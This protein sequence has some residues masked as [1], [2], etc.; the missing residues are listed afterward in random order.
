MN[1]QRTSL[2]PFDFNTEVVIPTAGNEKDHA[3][4]AIDEDLTDREDRTFRYVL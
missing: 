3:E 1:S 2:D 4:V